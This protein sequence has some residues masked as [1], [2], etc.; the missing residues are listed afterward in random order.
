MPTFDVDSE[1]DSGGVEGDGDREL[2]AAEDGE[3]EWDIEA[4]RE[5]GRL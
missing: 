3:V 4:E 2:N 1:E 5:G